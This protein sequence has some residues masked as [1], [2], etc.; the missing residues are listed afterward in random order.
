MS[1]KSKK[2]R[3]FTLLEVLITLAILVTMVFAV[4]QMVRSGFDVKDA[5]KIALDPEAKYTIKVSEGTS[6]QPA[7]YEVT[8]TGDKGST[9]V[10]FKV[11]P[12]QKRSIFGDQFDASPAVQMIRPYQEQ[13]R[14]LSI[15]YS[16][17]IWCRLHLCNS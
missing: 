17:R 10:K 1:V 5:R 15:F 7:M 14:S 8:A 12:E 13:I 6:I 2:E 3:A 4:A 11:T 16:T 9:I